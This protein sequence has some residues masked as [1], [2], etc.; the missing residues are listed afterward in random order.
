MYL[1]ATKTVPVDKLTWLGPARHVEGEYM[2]GWSD[3]CGEVVYGHVTMT[4]LAPVV[5][6]EWRKG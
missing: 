5:F 1:T 6:A 4:D 2:V 3:A